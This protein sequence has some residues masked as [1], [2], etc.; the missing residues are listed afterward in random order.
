MAQFNVKG[1]YVDLQRRSHYFELVS[2]CSDRTYIK[3]L[4]RAKFPAEEIFINTVNQN[5]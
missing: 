4:I 5:H 1:R 2:D 3:D